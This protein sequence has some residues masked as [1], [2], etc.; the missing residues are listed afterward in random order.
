MRIKLIDSATLDETSAKAALSGR[1]RMNHNFHNLSDNLQRMLN[2]IE[3]DSY[4]R[5]HR[6]LEPAKTELFLILRGRAAALLFDDEGR[7][8]DSK[9]LTPAGE[10]PGV[11]FIPGQYH[12]IISLEPGTVLFE[13]KDGPYVAVTDKDFAPWAPSAGIKRAPK[14]TFKG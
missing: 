6:H 2:A 12:S 5:P 1:R 13:V 14:S 11:E 10:C 8:M 7:I 3:P 4:V 9:V